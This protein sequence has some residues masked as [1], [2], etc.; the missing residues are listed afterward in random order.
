MN[1]I[2]YSMLCASIINSELSADIICPLLHRGR[3]KRPITQ[4]IR[5]MNV[6]QIIRP[7]SFDPALQP[8]QSLG[9]RQMSDDRDFSSAV[10]Y[11][12]TTY[13]Y[14][15]ESVGHFPLPPP[16]CANLHKAI[17]HNWK[18]A[19]TAFLTLTERLSISFAWYRLGH[20]G[21]GRGEMSYTMC[22]RKGNCPG[23]ECSGGTWP[24][25]YVQG[26]CLDPICDSFARTRCNAY[27]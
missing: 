7:F 10:I 24:W 18:L 23:G 15:C 6:G 17:Y 2:I 20:G 8:H 5:W 19:L 14:I 22:K 4:N 3:T 1:L 9:G 11:Q 21:G 16:P 25:Q 26:K 13:Q 27:S 12:A